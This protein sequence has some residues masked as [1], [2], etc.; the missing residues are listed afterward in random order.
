MDIL[1]VQEEEPLGVPADRRHGIAA[2]DLIVRDV[3]QQ[4]DVFWI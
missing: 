3:E 4:A 2:S 1:D